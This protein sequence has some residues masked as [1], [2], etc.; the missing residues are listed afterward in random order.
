M[1]L[2]Q[3]RAYIILHAELSTYGYTGAWKDNAWEIID[4]V[5]LI[6]NG[7]NLSQTYY[8]AANEAKLLQEI[9]KILHLTDMPIEDMI[10]VLEQLAELWRP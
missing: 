9:K 1:N 3:K 6:L 5:R 7:Q 10:L 8:Y 2:A 4:R